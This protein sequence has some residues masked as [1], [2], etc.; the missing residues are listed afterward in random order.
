MRYVIKQQEDG[1]YFVIDEWAFRV[2]VSDASLDYC[3]GVLAGIAYL[4]GH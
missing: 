2:I 3:N 1:L 4:G